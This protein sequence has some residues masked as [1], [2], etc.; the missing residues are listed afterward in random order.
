[1][2]EKGTRVLIAATYGQSNMVSVRCV[3][4]TR[5]LARGHSPMIILFDHVCVI[6][7]FVCFNL[8]KKMWWKINKIEWPEPIATACVCECIRVLLSYI[9]I[10]QCAMATPKNAFHFIWKFKIDYNFLGKRTN[11]Q[12]KNEC[13]KERNCWLSWMYWLFFRTTSNRHEHRSNIIMII[14]RIII[15]YIAYRRKEWNNGCSF[16]KSQ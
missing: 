8:I 5:L 13:G 2:M 16:C 11:E 7:L 4:R 3:V 14:M 15:I 12:Y 1:M 9:I 10:E 6:Y